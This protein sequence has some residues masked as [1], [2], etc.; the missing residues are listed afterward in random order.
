MDNYIE[1]IYNKL[2][3]LLKE[4]E[5]YSGN[6]VWVD[7]GLF[8][9]SCGD[10]WRDYIVEIAHT[11]EFV[12]KIF[13]EINENNF[14]AL[15]GN[16]ITPN[17]SDNQKIKTIFNIDC[18]IISAGLFGGKSDLIIQYFKD[19]KNIIGKMI[20]NDFFTSEQE[21]ISILLNNHTDIKYFDFE[22]WTD[23]QRAIL[24]VMGRY[25]ELE[26]KTETLCR[27]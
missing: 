26:Y 15:R 24:K 27:L 8:G 9:T 2:E 20:D 23:F 13:Q 14:I 18:K 22:N 19:Y 10:V 5:N 3:F 4:S 6:V 17:Y 12:L 16:G 11:E 7:A 21:I 25:S 1:V